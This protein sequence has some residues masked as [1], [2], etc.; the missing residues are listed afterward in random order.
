MSHETDFT[1]AF[2]PW[3]PP[4]FYFVNVSHS[5]FQ[6]G[7]TDFNGI[8]YIDVTLTNICG[9]STFTTSSRPLKQAGCR[10]TKDNSSKYIMAPFCAAINCSNS[11]LKRPELSFYRF[12][13]E[14]ERYF[15]VSCVKKWKE[16]EFWYFLYYNDD[17]FSDVRTQN[18][19]SNHTNLEDKHM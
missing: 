9:T 5:R 1:A 2:P 7:S 14:V 18:E 8:F 15:F 3:N 11:K 19:Q 10:L 4:W 6:G 16:I 13:R 17:A 12:P